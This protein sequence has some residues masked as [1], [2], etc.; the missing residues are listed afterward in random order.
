VRLQL[1]Q[2]LVEAAQAHGGQGQAAVP[3]SV[4]VQVDLPVAATAPAAA[5]EAA[6]HTF[7]NPRAVARKVRT[8][9]KE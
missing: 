9:T 4:R 6:P 7:P 2:G 8:G 5:P 3:A 1:L